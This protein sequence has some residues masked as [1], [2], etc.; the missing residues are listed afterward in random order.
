MPADHP[1]YAGTLPLWAPDVRQRLEDYDVIL[2][3]GMNQSRLYL[4]REPS[5]PIPEHV[6]L[7]QLDSDP[8][9][10]GKNYPVEIG[11]LGDPQ[12]GLAELAKRVCDLATPDQAQAAKRR[13]KE[14][15][16]VRAIE[17][18]G[19]RVEIEVQQNRRPMT[20]FT[21][22][23]AMC[24]ALPANAAVV[25]E[26]PT[27][28]H[29]LLERL[30][31]LKD[32]YAYFAHRGWALGW[33]LGSAIGVKLAWPVRPVV[34][35]LGDGAALYGIQGLWTA[36]HHRI[37]VT[38]VIANNAQYKILKVSGDVMQLPQM[39]RGNY[40]GTDLVDP[41]VDF[42]GLARSFG[43][44]SHWVTEPDDLSQRIRDVGSRTQPVLLDVAIER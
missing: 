14:Y 23:G 31:A 32:P 2:L 28:H 3:V 13:I 27:T 20:P 42:V 38:F 29:G 30:G 6:R 5:R 8:R 40:L 44:E 4:Y 21:F 33:G 34:A 16:A 9:E 36:A 43:V 10:I 37:P 41:E 17:Q 15:A 18:A 1:L 22:M 11:L 39:A 26:A 7:I 24:R 35:L 25:E 19:V 12:T